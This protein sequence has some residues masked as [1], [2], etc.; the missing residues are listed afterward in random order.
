MIKAVKQSNCGKCL[1]NL[2]YDTFSERYKSDKFLCDIC[3]KI[4]HVS[5]GIFTCI[6]CKFDVCSSCIEN[7]NLPDLT[8]LKCGYNIDYIHC[9]GD[10]YKKGQY[11]CNVCNMPYLDVAGVYH[12]DK[13]GN[14]VCN[15]CESELKKKI[16]FNQKRDSPFG[17]IL[18]KAG[19]QD[20]SIKEKK[21]IKK[22][23]R[24]NSINYVLK[25]DDFDDK[26]IKLQ[27]EEEILTF[28]PKKSKDN[29]VYHDNYPIVKENNE[30]DK[31]FHKTT[32]YVDG[33][34]VE[35]GEILKKY[36]EKFF[37]LPNHSSNTNP[38]IDYH[39]PY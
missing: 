34:P 16:V 39:K 4:H 19:I 35:Y 38:K 33:R 14:D 7:V 23:S 8:C 37:S 22:K 32:Y 6:D 9:L 29:F 11:F 31:L 26:N 21:E 30:L 20:S 12:C 36:G 28:N 17:E 1:K 18:K 13:C 5:T 10:P 27:N 24:N 15:N 3:L 2:K 25:F